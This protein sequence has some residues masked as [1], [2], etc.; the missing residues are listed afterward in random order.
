MSEESACLAHN[1]RQ[2][3]ETL[4][5]KG[6]NQIIFHACCRYTDT[7]WRDDEIIWKTILPLSFRVSRRQ[8]G[9]RPIF[10][11]CSETRSDQRRSSSTEQRKPIQSFVELSG[12][13]PLDSLRELIAESWMENTYP[14]PPMAAG[15]LGIW[16]MIR[17]IETLPDKNPDQLDV[18]D[19][20]LMRPSVVAIFDRLKDKLLY[21]TKSGPF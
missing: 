9:S 10:C 13:K 11:G 8:W 15:L 6:I 19:S 7:C 5:A 18:H 3:C 20:V 16:A 1:N 4:F 14:L 2:N 21:V 17:H 12:K